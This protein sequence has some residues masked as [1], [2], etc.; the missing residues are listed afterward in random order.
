MTRVVKFKIT[1]E[2]FST[3]CSIL[4]YMSVMARNESVIISVA[5]RFIVDENDEY[6]VKVKLDEDGDIEELE[7]VNE[8]LA[9][10]AK[11]TPKRLENLM[12][13]ISEAANAIVNPTKEK[14]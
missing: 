10:L 14:A 5:P 1:P 4:Q 12:D 13:E 6:I 3:A 9:E 2:R 7:G 11:V 8:A